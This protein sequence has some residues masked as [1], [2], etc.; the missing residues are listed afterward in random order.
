MLHWVDYV[1]ESHFGGTAV[2]LRQLMMYRVYCTSMVQ[3]Y[4]C[5]RGQDVS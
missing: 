3:H 2:D 5:A 4:S 1:L